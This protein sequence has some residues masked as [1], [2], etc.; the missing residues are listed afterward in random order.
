MA[1]L[2][3]CLITNSAC[4]AK[5][6]PEIAGEVPECLFDCHE[7]EEVEDDDDD[8]DDDAMFA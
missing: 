3:P 6:V 8:D 4:C 1:S 7:D 2:W 5:E